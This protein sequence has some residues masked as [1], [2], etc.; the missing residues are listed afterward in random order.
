MIGRE[1]VSG[2]RSTEDHRTLATKEP[3]F[4]LPCV[5]FRSSEQFEEVLG[6]DMDVIP[7]I[8]G[9]NVYQLGVA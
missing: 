1:N 8:I 4:T 3:C 6:F 5:V 7:A 9:G 2:Q